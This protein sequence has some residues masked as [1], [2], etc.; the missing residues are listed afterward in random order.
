MIRH[1]PDRAVS[2]GGAPNLALRHLGRQAFM[3]F[4]AA[5]C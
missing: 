1:S 3:F 5:R 2:G 4:L